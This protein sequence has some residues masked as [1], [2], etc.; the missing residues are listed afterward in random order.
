MCY[1]LSAVSAPLPPGS[2]C[3]LGAALMSSH[4][5]VQ[6]LF[7]YIIGQAQGSPEQEGTLR[8]SS[9]PCPLQILKV[10]PQEGKPHALG[11]MAVHHEPSFLAPRT[12]SS[13]V[14]SAV[15]QTIKLPTV[16]TPWGLQGAYLSLTHFSSR[17]R[18]GF[19]EVNSVTC[20]AICWG[21]FCAFWGRVGG[22]HWSLASLH[23][24][25]IWG[26]IEHA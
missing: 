11:H 18:T 8:T 4:R 16:S 15:F 17:C 26:E 10:R 5:G 25:A 22:V 2:S 9:K 21:E 13:T 6:S 23:F 14:H 12:P 19:L 7:S 1:P 3:W 20:L 24:L